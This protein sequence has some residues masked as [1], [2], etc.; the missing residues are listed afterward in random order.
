MQKEKRENK[1]KFSVFQ[2]TCMVLIA[3]LVIVI[4]VQIGVMVYLKEKT[5]ELNDK[6]DK[7]P[8]VDDDEEIVDQEFWQ[9][10]F[11]EAI[12]KNDDIH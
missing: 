12:K 11:L 4:I 1:R 2:I 7:L 10:I 9:P 6:N 3:V 5:D 8:V